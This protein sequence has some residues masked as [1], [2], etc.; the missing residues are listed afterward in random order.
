MTELARYILTTALSPRGVAVWWASLTL[1][2]VTCLPAS[3]QSGLGRITTGPAAAASTTPLSAAVQQAVAR[4]LSK[5]RHLM[6]EGIQVV[7]S[8]GI[9][10]LS[11]RVPVLLWRERAARVA[12]A[13]HGVRGVVNRIRIEP[14]RRPDRLV[15]KDAGAAVRDTA[16]LATMPITIAVADGVLVLSG[17]ITT[18]EEQQ[19][20]E[21]VVSAVPGVRFCQNQLAST[22]TITRTSA[23]MAADVRSRLDWDPLV[24]SA[25]IVVSARGARVLLAGTVASPAERRRAIAHAWVKGVRAVDAKALGIDTTGG[26]EHDVRDRFPTDLEI[27]SAIQDLAAY[28]PPVAAPGLNTSVAAGVTVQTLAEKRALERVVGS[29]IGVVA[30]RSELRGPWFTPPV[31]PPP[32]RPIQRTRTRKGR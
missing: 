5:D 26:T 9:V 13:V 16:A 8:N 23:I 22:R 17:F 18:W 6:A 19:L 25:R 28:W 21:R 30:V 20:A 3:A 11:G 15:A 7:V 1:A 12:G 29:A 32:A 24:Q 27:S 10:V 2:S 14:I 31:A 4:K